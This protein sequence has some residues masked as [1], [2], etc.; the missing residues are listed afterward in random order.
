MSKPLGWDWVV[1]LDW[2]VEQ[3]E[4]GVFIATCARL[5]LVAQGHTHKEA[6]EEGE[7]LWANLCAHLQE[8]GVDVVEYMK[9]R[10]V[11]ASKAGA[12]PPAPAS[13]EDR[14][15]TII[16]AEAQR[17]L[18][19]WTW[20]ARFRIWN[21]SP[22]PREGLV[23]LQYRTAQWAAYWFNKPLGVRGDLNEAVAL[24]EK[25]AHR[26]GWVRPESDPIA[27][28]RARG[29]VR[30]AQDWYT[31]RGE[32]CAWLIEVGPDSG[33]YRSWHQEYTYDSEAEALDAAMKAWGPA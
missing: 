33:R 10:G 14:L 24:V 21:M 30:R 18:P 11:R 17:A 6:M 20:D 29:W 25:E 26:A 15:R 2:V 5:G 1:E 19:G 9:L 7:A 31:A 3:P 4:P 8:T 32:A 23:V 27:R 12:A 13:I 16:E 28:A 22:E